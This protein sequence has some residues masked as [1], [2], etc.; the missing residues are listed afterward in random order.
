MDRFKIKIQYLCLALLLYLANTV[1]VE[2]QTRVVGKVIDEQGEPIPFANIIFKKSMVGTYSNQKGE[3][4]LYSQKNY[5][6]IEVSSVGYTTKEIKLKSNDNHLQVVLVMGE[7]LEEVVVVQKPTKNLSKKENP[8]YPILQKIWANKYKNALSTAKA[9]QYRRYETVELGLN[10]LDS[11]FLKKALQSE[12]Q[13]VR[14]LLS[15]KKYKQYFSMPMY[16]KEEV[17]QVYGDNERSLYRTDIEGERTQGVIQTG[18]GLERFTRNFREFNVYDNSFYL[19][20]KTFVSPISE[21]G[22]GVYAYVLNDTIER[23][24]RKFYSIYFFPKQDQDLLFKGNFTVDSKTYAIESIQMYT[25]KEAS[26]NF[27]RNLSIE[28]HYQWVND[29]LIL[30]KRDYYE[31]DFTI[32]TKSDEEKGMYVRKNI[33]YSDYLLDSP[34]EQSFYLASVEKYKANQFKQSQEYWAQLGEGDSQMSKTQTLIRKVGD[35]KRIKGISDALNIITSGYIRIGRYMQFGSLWES[36]TNNDVERN[37]FRFG[38]RSFVSNDDR[39]RTY[40]Y[41]AYGTLDQKF[42][43]G[44]SAKYLAFYKPRITI[45]GLY[46]NDYLQLGNILQRNDAELNL[47]NASNFLFARGENYYL[48]QN[49]RI[50]GVADIGLLKSNL[51]ITL[52][53]MYQQ[54]KAAD[55]EH[56]SIGYRS[57]NGVLDKYSDANASLTLTYTPTRNVYGYGVEQF[58]GKNI[59]PTFSLKYTKGF[60]GIRNSLFDYSRLEGMI[61]YP[62]PMWSIGILHTVVEAG[63]V[64]GTVPLPLLTPTPANQTYASSGHKLNRTFQLLDYYDFVT[65]AYLNVY[66]E[67]HFN[68]FVMNRIPL[69]KKTKWRSLILARMAYGTLRE[70]NRLISASN[71]QYNAPEKLY[72]E[73]GFGIENIGIG[74]FRPIRVDFLW[75]SSFTDLNGVSNPYFGIRFGIKPEF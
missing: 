48:T 72:W 13:E 50:Q 49:K 23:N 37:R 38:L 18:F 62:Q 16:L 41:G 64:Y 57:E 70:E 47:K 45:G 1:L 39:F 2:A 20:D 21:Y 7:E 40:L 69:L 68:G 17:S 35:N 63:K 11:L 5:N 55:P 24:D 25:I 51:H 19:L 74:N 26:L 6:A 4:T 34:K 71:I 43:Y 30:P 3:F 75:R 46:Q 58:Y 10:N 53:G 31:G 65:D 73:Y 28:K 54:M 44:V 61:H 60:S 32:L 42:K 56:F 33:V 8:A 15:E 59:F 27:V 67:H 29:S 52:S 12:Y 22:Y 66:A 14:N 36:F 9:Y